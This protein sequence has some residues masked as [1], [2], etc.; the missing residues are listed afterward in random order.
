MDNLPVLSI[1][2]HHSL[3]CDLHLTN[4]KKYLIKNVKKSRLN[5]GTRNRQMIF[6]AEAAGQMA[7]YE[8][9]QNPP[10]ADTKWKYYDI[11]DWDFQGKLLLLD[12]LYYEF[13][14]DLSV[15]N[16]K[17]KESLFS[18]EAVWRNSNSNTIL[19]AAIVTTYN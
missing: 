2:S 15:I 11:T 19:S 10:F 12:W 9:S 6:C 16:A 17:Y 13:C 14:W 3:V 8:P 1:L 7:R 4:F 5:S 18:N